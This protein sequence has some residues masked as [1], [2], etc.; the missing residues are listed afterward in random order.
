MKLNSV[1]IL[2][3]LCLLSTSVTAQKLNFVKKKITLV[4]VFKEIT[5]QTDYQVIWNE[6]K[7]NVDQRIDADFQNVSLPQVM[8]RIL[9]GLPLT[10]IISKKMIIINSSPIIDVHGIV[11]NEQNQL[12]EGAS[13]SVKGE[14]KITVTD[15]K[16]QYLLKRVD[17]GAT[18]II[19]YVGC[20]NKEI[21]ALAKMEKVS[22]S[23]NNDLLKEVEVVSTGYQKIPKQR[24]TGSFAL[25]DSMQFARKVSP[26][27]LS[28]LEG[29][30]SGLL[31]NRNTVRANSGALDLSVRGR[32]TIFANDQP[33]IILDNFPFDGDFNFINP[34]DIDTITVLKDA[35]AASIWGVRAGNGVIVI[36][37]KRGKNKQPLSVS[38]NSNVTIAGKPNLSYNPNYLSSS[39]YIDVETFLFDHG[40]YDKIL[41]DP[42][43]YIAVSPVVQILNKQRMGQSADETTRQLNVLRSKDLRNDEIKYFYRKAVSQQYAMSLSGGTA[44]TNH[45]FSAGYDKTDATLIANNNRRIT[46][47]SQNTLR[48]VKNLELELGVY[49]SKLTS[50]IDSTLSEI[51]FHTTPYY[52]FRDVNG[53]NTV[54]DHDFNADFRKEA[55]D[56]GF[57]DWSYVPLNELGKSLRTIKDNNLRLNGGL[58]YTIITG[59]S[60]T[61]KYQ[62]QEFDSRASQYSGI[63]TFHIRNLINQYSILTSGKVSGYNIPLG[64]VLSTNNGKASSNNLRTQL[65]YEKRWQKNSISAIMGYE[66]SESV[67][68]RNSQT[69][70]GYDPNS[71]KSI[72]VDTTG[73]FNLNPLGSGQI[74]TSYRFFKRTNRMRSSYINAAYTYDGRY[75]LSASARADG[76]NYFGIK[77]NQ[78]YV[79][80]W[81]AGALWNVDREDFYKL[82]WLPVLKFRASYGYNGNL[83]KSNT[84]ITTLRYGISG[85]TYTGLPYANIINIG[86]PE[87][88]WEKVAI[89]NVGIEFGLRNSAI[90]GKVE[91]YIK[92]GSDILGDKAFASNSGIKVLRGNYSK[93]KTKGLDI[94]LNSQNLKGKLGWTT[95]FILSAVHDWVTDYHAVQPASIYYVGTYSSIPILNRPVYGIYSYKWAGLD[96]LNGDPRGY[97]NGQV[98]KDYKTI[99]NSTIEDI[100]YNGR[101]MPTVFGGLNNV[102]SF[103]K[104]TLAFNISYKFGYYFRK[105]TIEYYNLY[106][107]NTI[108][109]MSA[110]FENRWQKSGDEATTNIPSMG[111]FGEDGSRDKFYSSSS[112]TIARGD[113]I[114]LQDVSIS[115]DFD[116]SNW[117]NIPVK[118]L[119]LYFYV[120]NLGIIW[121]ANDFRLDPDLVPSTGDRYSNQIAKSFAIGLKVNF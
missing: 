110:D 87:L 117:K 24:A 8:N 46:I 70:Y 115:F 64:G 11:I 27:V 84:G 21:K 30:T 108:S 94:S 10:Y 43:N 95:S 103:Q 41:A 20:Q 88:K 2:S 107:T 63:E 54:L 112:A 89:A 33:L 60:A 98:S 55:L 47:N 65:N 73:Y 119:Q 116:P 97:V 75:T 5:R 22:L 66:I 59:L 51:S 34:N 82:S 91:Y 113:H 26:D 13:V 3:I 57:L 48:P 28:R 19:S 86:N 18:L 74:G 118:Q 56:K 69:K 6:Q 49:Y 35:A 109:Y 36:T 111:S 53:R 79:P 40:K 1:F 85:A 29:I 104:F 77:T 4:Q 39:D 15:A 78:K 23:L 58:T 81:S 16:G 67:S 105:P 106:N 52:Q 76:S 102:F 83:D 101:A 114:R 31:F 61:I 68:D 14:N 93:L 25:V 121:K 38:V 50:N 17:T 32:S 92:N 9:S 120:N 90:S 96:P 62:Y 7:L 99:L 45:Y 100:E 44:K 42:H 80:L 12:L 72:A 71:G 37:T